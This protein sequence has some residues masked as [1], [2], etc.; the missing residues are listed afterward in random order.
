MRQSSL[1]SQSRFRDNGCLCIATE[2]CQ[3]FPF[4]SP[5]PWSSRK[6]VSDVLRLWQPMPSV[7]ICHHSGRYGRQKFWAGQVLLP[8]PK[9]LLDESE[10]AYG[11]PQAGTFSLNQISLAAPE[12]QTSAPLNFFHHDS[13]IRCFPSST[14]SPSIRK[15]RLSRSI[16][17]PSP[18]PSIPF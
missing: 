15:L 13:T 6:C 12:Q 14:T 11:V 2:I 16:S 7:F 1:V 3:P 18:P 17:N 5:W 4:S 10:A 8:P 9:V